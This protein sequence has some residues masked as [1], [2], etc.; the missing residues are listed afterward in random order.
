[1]T[2]R[3]DTATDWA[4]IAGP[5]AEALLGQP[6]QRLSRRTEYR[7]GRRGS[8]RV[9][10]QRGTWNDFEAGEG[11]GVI[12]L[13]RREQRCDTTGALQWFQHHGARVPP[14]HPSPARTGTRR[15]APGE[16]ARGI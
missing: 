14:R 10:L 16:C 8:L 13:V 2:A 1:M 15:T 5:V 11:G 3:R 12:D 9:D 4:A 7:Y 6:N